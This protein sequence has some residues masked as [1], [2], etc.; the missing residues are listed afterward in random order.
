MKGAEFLTHEAI[1]LKNKGMKKNK[2]KSEFLWPLQ[3][4]EE[5]RQVSVGISPLNQMER[6]V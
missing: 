5:S 3:E 1:T 2:I 4:E 6:V